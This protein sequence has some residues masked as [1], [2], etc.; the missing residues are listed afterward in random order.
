MANTPQNIFL[1]SVSGAVI[2]EVATTAKDSRTY[3]E[4]WLTIYNNESLLNEFTVYQN[5]G[6][7]DLVLAVKKVQSGKSWIVDE[8]TGSKLSK[9]QS[10]KVKGANATSDYNVSLS[11]AIIDY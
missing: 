3:A 4:L 5:N 7:D 9:D 10:I 1:G 11:A 8:L 2:T 6:T